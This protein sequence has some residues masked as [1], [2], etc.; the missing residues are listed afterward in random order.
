MEVS[1]ELL[2]PASSTAE[3]RVLATRFIGDWMVPKIG[4]YEIWSW[5]E[6]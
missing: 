1:R 5:K 4:F 3:E 2:A 6:F